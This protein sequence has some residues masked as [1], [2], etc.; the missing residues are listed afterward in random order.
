MGK[1]CYKL[2]LN[3]R[4][5]T[6]QALSHVK[7]RKPEESAALRKLVRCFYVRE[8]ISA[9]TPG[10]R[11][12]YIVRIRPAGNKK[13]RVVKKYVQVSWCFSQ[14]NPVVHPRHVFV[15]LVGATRTS[16]VTNGL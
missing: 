14:C 10:I 6:D 16:Q 1:V 8:D 4:T 13:G 3:Q 2:G 5:M 11:Q 7:K 12:Y 9:V 15:C